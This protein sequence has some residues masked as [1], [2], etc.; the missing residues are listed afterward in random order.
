MN[1]NNL[2]TME[3]NLRSIA[4]RYENVKYSV[5]LAVLFLMKG[6]SAFSDENKIQEVEKQKEVITNDQIAKSTVKEVK[7]QETKKVKT[8]T[9]KPKASWAT[10]Q[11]GANDMYSNFFVAPKT[12]VEK[13]S[14]VKN[15][16]TILVA[17]A[18]NSIVLPMFAKLSSDIETIDTNTPTMEEIKVGKEN[19]RDSV[20]NLKDKIDVARRENNKEINGLKLELIQLMEQGNQ[21]VKSPW[22]SW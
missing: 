16:K 18:D 21:V 14:I 8:T 13:T 9:Q 3:K 7:K 6:T 20:G 22:S 1:S 17:S 5:G 15:E 12:E 2:D 4:K 19:I 11:F 10:M